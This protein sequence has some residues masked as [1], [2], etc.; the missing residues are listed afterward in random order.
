M[1]AI[2]EP[3]SPPLVGDRRTRYSTCIHTVIPRVYL[4]ALHVYTPHL[5][6][7]KCITVSF[8]T[9]TRHCGNH[10]ASHVCRVIDPLLL[11]LKCLY[12]RPY[13]ERG[14]VRLGSIAR[15][16]IRVRDC[17]EEIRSGRLCQGLK[18]QFD[19]VLHST[20]T[21]S[22]IVYRSIAPGCVVQDLNV[23]LNDCPGQDVT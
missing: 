11:S 9:Q 17:H 2:I 23:T 14:A 6:A 22:T 19:T 15:S 20:G 4:R 7:I 13:Y 3:P 10:L 12:I 16:F 18:W 1:T 21:N 5:L 8:G